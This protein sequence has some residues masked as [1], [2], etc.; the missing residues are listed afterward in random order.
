MQQTNSFEQ[1]F[2][3]SIGNYRERS[4]AVLEVCPL[5]SGKEGLEKASEKPDNNLCICD[6][7]AWVL[8]GGLMLDKVP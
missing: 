4:P 5:Q 3:H 2:K 8:K 7:S 6:L 1:N